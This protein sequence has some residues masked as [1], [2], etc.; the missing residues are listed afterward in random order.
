MN[1]GESQIFKLIF[2]NPIKILIIFFFKFEAN[3]FLD[4][5]EITPDDTILNEAN[6]KKLLNPEIKDQNVVVFCV[7]GDSFEITD[8]VVQFSL[9][10]LYSNVSLFGVVHK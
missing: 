9:H 1:S 7:Y 10:Y 3:G 2:S 4:L 5:I 8:E 6:W